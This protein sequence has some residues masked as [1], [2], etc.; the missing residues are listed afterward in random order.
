MYTQLVC[1]AVAQ[2][3]KSDWWDKRRLKGKTAALEACGRQQRWRGKS[4]SSQS[5]PRACRIQA[6]SIQRGSV[7]SI[8]PHKTTYTYIMI[9]YL[10]DVLSQ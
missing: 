7:T 4:Y 10:D 2:N 8:G 9:I 3:H 6:N 5:V 1:R